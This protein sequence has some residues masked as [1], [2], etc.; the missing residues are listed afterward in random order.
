MLKKTFAAAIVAT[1]IG[2]G[3]PSFMPFAPAAAV[4]AE[5]KVMTA[6]DLRVALNQLLAEHA[7]LAASAT[8][9]ALRGRKVEFAA[10]A[11]A[12][13][14]NSIDIANAMGLAYGPA[15]GEAFLPLW[16]KHIGFFVDYTVGKAKGSKKMQD[17][18]VADLLGYAEDFGAFLNSASPALPKDAVAGLVKSHI[19]SLKDVVDAQAAKDP[20]LAYQKIR[21]AAHH[22]QMVADPLAATLAAQFPEKFP[23]L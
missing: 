22:M 20:K 12:L 9:A 5:M 14:N 13:D 7:T 11:G 4:A 8:G 18:A 2:F 1:A 16:R 15:A 21:E 6:G 19:L 23:A 3:G 17:K 10:A